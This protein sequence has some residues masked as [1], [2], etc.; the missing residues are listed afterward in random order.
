[1][2]VVLL[3]TYSCIDQERHS[4]K[5]HKAQVC[6]G[7]NLFIYL[8]GLPPPLSFNMHKYCRGK[9]CCSDIVW[10]YFVVVVVVCKL[11]VNVSVYVCVCVCL[12]VCV[13]V[14]VMIGSSSS[15]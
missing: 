3:L 14:C 4:C 12:C 11:F 5:N 13:Y 7:R 6:D 2:Y 15:S 9:D 10:L 8:S 1:M